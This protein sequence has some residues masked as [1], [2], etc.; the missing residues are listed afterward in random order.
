MFPR[1][2]SGST[3]PL[4]AF[5]L[6]RSYLHPVPRPSCFATTPHMPDPTASSVFQ[7]S[8]PPSLLAITHP[9]A[10]PTARL[11]FDSPANPRRLDMHQTLSLPHT[12]H[13]FVHHIN[14]MFLIIS[15]RDILLFIIQRLIP[16]WQDLEFG[17]I[18]NEG[19]VVSGF[20]LGRSGSGECCLD[21]C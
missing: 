21:L 16:L 11:R 17:M 3:F 5:N 8:P 10:L 20:V 6:S 9:S 12:R 4:I 14:F 19:W 2:R 1:A 13:R 7:S 18:Q 15:T